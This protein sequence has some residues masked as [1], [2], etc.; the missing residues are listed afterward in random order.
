M[1][2]LDVDW[3][4]VAAAGEVA[5]TSVLPA[6]TTIDGDTP[7]IS[8]GAAFFAGLQLTSNE[9]KQSPAPLDVSLLLRFRWPGLLPLP[10]AQHEQFFFTLPRVDERRLVF[11]GVRS[12][13]QN[14]I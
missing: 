13:W 2:L 7:A 6:S 12:I 8:G 3:I 1:A 9:D 10:L 14:R 4:A 11:S 5:A